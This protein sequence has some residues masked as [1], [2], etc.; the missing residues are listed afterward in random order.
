QTGGTYT[1]ATATDY[2]IRPVNREWLGEPGN[3]IVFSNLSGTYFT[4]G[5]NTVQLTGKLG[6]AVVPPE[7]ERI[8]A[9]AVVAQH[10]TKGSEGPRAVIGP[11][12]RAV[13]LRDISP[14]DY[15]TLIGFQDPTVA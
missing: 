6:W 1:T 7:V 12:G 10:L 3:S 8:A 5:Y 15:A 2:F 13:I 9:S 4:A 11:D 14:A